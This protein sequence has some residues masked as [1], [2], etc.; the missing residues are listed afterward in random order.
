MSDRAPPP[1]VWNTSTPP[2]MDA[3]RLM[4][5]DASKKSA[6][7][8]YL[9]WFFLGG[10]GVHRFYLGQTGTGIV[11]AIIFILSWA[12]T[13]I[14][15]GFFGLVIEKARRRRDECREQDDQP[16]KPDEQAHQPI[17]PCRRAHCQ[18]SR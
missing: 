17:C 2:S 9:L 1:P 10:L 16:D 15:I 8:A 12:T 5:Y 3:V 11:M 7:L 4:Q 14:V 18:K 6:G 13:F